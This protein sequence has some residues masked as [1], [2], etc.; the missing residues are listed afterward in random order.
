MIGR[1]RK[2]FFTQKNIDNQVIEFSKKLNKNDMIIDIGAG[3]QRFK[4]LFKNQI[5]K[6]QDYYSDTLITGRNGIQKQ[7]F[8]KA[9][10][11]DI[12]KYKYK[13]AD[14]LCD[15]S[16][17]PVKDNTFDAAICT[18]VFEHLKHPNLALKE[19]FRILKPNG[20]V[21]I[22]TPIACIRH[23]DP[24]FY[25]YGLTDNWFKEVGKECGFKEIIISQ[26][27]NYKSFMAYEIARSIK[28]FGVLSIPF[29]LPS[30]IYYLLSSWNKKAYDSLGQH[31][32]FVL[33]K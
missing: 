14:Y 25:N 29:L 1:I 33:T 28:S 10:G 15:I 19:I 16:N 18:E 23:M 32:Y 17:I 27:G 12:D 9:K 22:T 11:Y 3:S 2:T 20:K 31:S 24:V 6:S 26:K 4:Y 5:Y 13:N 8:V 21:L 7:S 30:F